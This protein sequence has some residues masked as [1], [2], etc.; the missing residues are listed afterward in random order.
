MG[1]ARVVDSAV[2]TVR[3][4]LVGPDHIVCVRGDIDAATAPLL[5]DE[6]EPLLASTRHVVL[7]LSQ[8]GFVDSPGVAVIIRAVNVLRER[9]QRLTVREPA[10][11][12]QRVFETLG[13]TRLVSIE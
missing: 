13:L 6:L 5:E 10:P 12:T 3:H 4:E 8:V 7:D 1:T 11:M 2:F 9:G